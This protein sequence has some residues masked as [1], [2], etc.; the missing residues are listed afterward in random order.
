MLDRT[1]PRVLIVDDHVDLGHSIAE[2]VEA[3]GY[4]A[5]LTTTSEEYRRLFHDFRP[6]WVI[7][8]IIMPDADGIELANWTVEQDPHVRVILV[9][10]FNPFWGQCAQKL[11]TVNAVNKVAFLQ[12]PISRTALSS[13]LGDTTTGA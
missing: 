3:L 1:T 13:A 5:K 6:G 7:V 11:V 9:S 10:G 2:T 12:K 4:L 8:D